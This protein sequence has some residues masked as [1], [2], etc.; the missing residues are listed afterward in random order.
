MECL[1]S[2]LKSSVAQWKMSCA[3]LDDSLYQL[4]TTLSQDV[5]LVRSDL[6]Q[7]ASRLAHG[8]EARSDNEH[9]DQ[10]RTL[11]ED[12]RREVDLLRNQCPPCALTLQPSVVPFTETCGTELH[13]QLHAQFL[14]QMEMVTSDLKC[15]RVDSWLQGKTSI[16]GSSAS[17]HNENEDVWFASKRGRQVPLPHHA[18]VE[19]ANIDVPNKQADELK[20]CLKKLVTK[21]NQ[22]FPSADQQPESLSPTLSPKR[23][24]VRKVSPAQDDTITVPGDMMLP[25]Q[26]ATSTGSHA[27]PNVAP[28]YSNTALPH[29][30]SVSPQSHQ[31]T[32]NSHSQANEVAL[33]ARPQQAAA[34][35]LPVRRHACRTVSSSPQ[36]WSSPQTGFGSPH[37]LVP[38]RRQSPVKAPIMQC[39]IKSQGNEISAASTTVVGR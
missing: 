37:V 11:L 2:E 38:E 6:D 17:S 31:R 10:R 23:C 3:D 4:R 21:I 33:H 8:T 35:M 9:V 32:V 30:V 19:T 28:S 7:L 16:D 22:T 5:K 27:L 12:L 25:G 34:V 13:P 20:N 14:P 26:K 15:Q 1:D 24:T 39:P 29:R 18:E 36:N